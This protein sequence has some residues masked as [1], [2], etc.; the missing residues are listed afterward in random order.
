MCNPLYN[1][2][3]INSVIYDLQFRFKQKYSTCHALIRLID[4]VREQLDSRHFSS[5][6]FL[7]FKKLLTQ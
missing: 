2:L 7:I 6:I 4:K 3:E 5:G 1:V